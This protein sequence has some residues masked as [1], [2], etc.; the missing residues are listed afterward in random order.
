[1]T[2]AVV[3][4]PDGGRAFVCRRTPPPPQKLEDT[5][6]MPWGKHQGSRMQ[7]VPASYFHWLWT[8][9]GKGGPLKSRVG[10]PV[11]DYVRRNRIA[12]EQ[13]YPDGIWE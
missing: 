2:C 8:D 11:A 9:G 3:T 13:E 4:L 6:A 1:M 12:L 5:D 10:C 7:D